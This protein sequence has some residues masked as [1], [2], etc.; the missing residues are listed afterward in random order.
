MFQKQPPEVFYKI[1]DLKNFAKFSEKHLSLSFSF[2]K[3]AGLM[4]AT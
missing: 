2:K 3:V 4:L 1:S